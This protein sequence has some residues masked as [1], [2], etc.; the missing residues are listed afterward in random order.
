ME[1]NAIDRPETFAEVWKSF[2]EM[3]NGALFGEVLWCEEDVWLEKK[4]YGV[5]RTFDFEKY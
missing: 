3:S 2:R 1:F 4:F 5:R